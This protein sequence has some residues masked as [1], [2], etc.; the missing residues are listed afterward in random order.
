LQHDETD[1]GAAVLA[2]V[3]RH[4]GVSIDVAR[5]RDLAHTDRGGSNLLG[6]AEAAEAVGFLAK[7]A[8]AEPESLDELPLPVVA[9]VVV[10]GMGHFVVLYRIKSGKVLVAD[11]AVG[12]GWEARDSF[13]A[14]WTGHLLLLT[15][16]PRLEDTGQKRSALGRLAD[17]A[18]PHRGLIVEACLCGVLYTVLGLGFSFYVQVLVDQVLAHEDLRLLHWLGWGMVALVLLRVLFSALREYLATHLAIKVDLLLLLQYYR[19]LLGLPMRFFDTRKVGEILSRMSDVAKIRSAI[20]SVVMTVAVDALMVLVSLAVMFLCDWRLAL[21]VV[22][23]MPLFLASLMAFLRPL[24]RAQRDAMQACADA[25]A[26]A[27]ESLSGIAELKAK[28]AGWIASQKSESLIVRTMRRAYRAAMLTVG[29]RMLASLCASLASLVML[30][31]GGYRV[32]TS[33]LS[34]G[35]LMFFY[36]LLGYT[37]AP[38]ERLVGVSSVVQEALVA[39]DRLSEVLDCEPEGPARPSAVRLDECRGLIE[40]RGVTFQ[41]GNREPALRDV[42]FRIEPGQTVAL[43]GP[44]GSGKTTVVNL[45]LRFYDPGEGQVLLDDVDLRD[46]A[47]DSLRRRVGLVAQSPFFF[48]G[49]VLDNIRLADPLAPM[50]EVRSAAQAADIHDFIVGLPERYDTPV[51]ERGLALSGGQRQRLAI[52]RALLVQPEVLVLDEG[53][54]ALDA[55]SERAVQTALHDLRADRTT[56]VVAHRLST[57]R[58][59][60]RVLVL[61]RGRLV[62]QGSHDELLAAEGLYHNL[63]TQQAIA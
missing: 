62:E 57:V 61:D 52:A 11:P 19:H 40:F 59:V 36:T 44:S 17:A 22:L 25:E 3:A 39:A 49:T 24:R 54:S 58:A 47:L 37:L 38:L 60:D 26:Y 21:V 2:S 15:P 30:W 45:L 16:S 5:L 48:S 42:S 14:K 35:Q 27:V 51:G 46:V 7:G 12:L 63:W 33:D 13:V 55:A 4:Y 43:V 10:G 29:S 56:L 32:I 31:Y 20:S 18:R 23:F 53:T 28:V 34:L 50:D 8:A 9:H 6:L 1:C 41:Y